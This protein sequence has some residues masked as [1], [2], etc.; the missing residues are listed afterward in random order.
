[1]FGDAKSAQS[2]LSEIGQSL[3]FKWRGSQLGVANRLLAN[4]ISKGNLKD[5]T[6][7][8]WG[9]LHEDDLILGGS[10]NYKGEHDRATWRPSEDRIKLAPEEM[11]TVF[12]TLKIP[13]PSTESLLLHTS[14]PD[15]TG[16]EDEAL[17]I[18]V[19]SSTDF[20]T[21][22]QVQLQTDWGQIAGT[23]EIN[24]SIHPQTVLCSATSNSSVLNLLP[25]ET[26]AWSGTPVFNGVSC[27]L[28]A[29]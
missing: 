28:T 20:S 25:Q 27:T 21:G 22:Q 8:V 1:V 13:T 10:M 5:W 17:V 15:S 11:S 29:I 18:Q 7:R 3:S 23:I 19:H 12:N 16:S 14:H 2:I 9:L 4:Q 26:D 6:Q 24:D